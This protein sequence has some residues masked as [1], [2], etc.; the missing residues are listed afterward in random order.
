MK[1]LLIT[2]LLATCAGSALAANWGGVR[3][4]IHEGIY[5]VDKAKREGAREVIAERREAAR[6]YYEADTPWEKR[7]AIREGAREVRQAK[8]KAYFDVQKEKR[9]A[10]REI[11]REYYRGW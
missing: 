7:Q 5:E 9:E 11:R 4:E 3:H 8:A 6:D 1:K 10:R 2:L